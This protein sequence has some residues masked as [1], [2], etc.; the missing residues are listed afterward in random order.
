MGKLRVVKYLVITISLIVLY[1]LLGFAFGGNHHWMIFFS[2]TGTFLISVYLF[3]RYPRQQ[4]LFISLLLVLPIILS[5]TV[6]SIPKTF[7]LSST[8][9]IFIPVSCYLAFIFYK[10][11]KLITM[12]LSFILFV[13]ISF[14]YFPNQLLYWSNKQ[15]RDISDYTEIVLLNKDQNTVRLDDSKI[16]I[17]DFWHTACVV[18]FEKFPDFEKSYLKFKDNPNIEFY[19]VNVPI[20]GNTHEKTVALVNKLDYKFPTLYTTSREEAEKNGLYEYPTIYIIKDG[21]ITYK[22]PLET[23]PHI[24]FYNFN[25][26]I[27]RNLEDL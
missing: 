6:V 1:I 19:S 4:H 16:T 12:I 9:I 13:L 2:L 25:N 22:G 21:K 3:R 5:L 8:Y 10:K 7:L 15:S 27:E 26:E 18:C 14:I 11:E 23:R 17:L 20:R 24:F